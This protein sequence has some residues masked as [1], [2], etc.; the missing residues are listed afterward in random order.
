M[1]RKSALHLIHALPGLQVNTTASVP[2]SSFFHVDVQGRAAGSHFD[3]GQGVRW[4]T[5]TSDWLLV[6]DDGGSTPLMCYWI[7]GTLK[8]AQT[9]MPLRLLLLWDESSTDRR[10]IP[11]YHA[12]IRRRAMWDSDEQEGFASPGDFFRRQTF[13]GR[14]LGPSGSVWICK[15]IIQQPLAVKCAGELPSL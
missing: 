15:E 14:S 2:Q 8:V 6:E 5:R 13:L 3:Q 1:V 9:G 12:F 10:T 7:A 4:I 11:F